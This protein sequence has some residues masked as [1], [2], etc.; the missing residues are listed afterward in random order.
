MAQRSSSVC[1]GTK[2]VLQVLLGEVESAPHLSNDRSKMLANTDYHIIRLQA[3][4]HKDTRADIVAHAP[5]CAER[6]PPIGAPQEQITADILEAQ[7]IVARCGCK[8]G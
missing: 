4:A 5:L 8:I 3:T 1:H 7:P 6:I 2:R